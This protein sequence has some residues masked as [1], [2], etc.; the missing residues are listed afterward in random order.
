MR[1]SMKAATS[2]VPV[3]R[4]ADLSITVPLTTGRSLLAPSPLLSRPVVALKGRADAS[5][6]RVPMVRLYGS[7]QLSAMTARW[8]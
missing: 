6:V 4:N 3:P 7:R 1:P 5:W 2:C 8:R